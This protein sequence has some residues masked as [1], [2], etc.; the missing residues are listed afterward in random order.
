LRAIWITTPRLT[1][2]FCRKH[3]LHTDPPISNWLPL[4]L[5]QLR[6]RS[7]SSG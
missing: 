6:T 7:F 3:S 4:T 1:N 2:L 5:W